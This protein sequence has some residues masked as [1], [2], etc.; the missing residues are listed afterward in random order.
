MRY[1][2]WDMVSYGAGEQ[3]VPF[4]LLMKSDDYYSVYQK[5]QEQIKKNPCVI[6]ASKN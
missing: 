5:F 2:L 1:E 4:T 3:P 6:F